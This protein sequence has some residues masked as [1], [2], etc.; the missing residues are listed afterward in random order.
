MKCSHCKIVIDKFI[1]TSKDTKGKPEKQWVNNA[2]KVAIKAKRQAWN[3]L[4]KTNYNDNDLLIKWKQSRNES[5]KITNSA[6]SNYESNIILDSKVNPKSFWSYVKKKT[7]KPGD[8]SS[9]H[10]DNNDIIVKDNEKATLLNNYFLS[11]F[12]TEPDDNFFNVNRVNDVEYTLSS[13]MVEETDISKIIN[14]VGVS[15]SAGPDNIHARLIKE[16]NKIF[17]KIFC[18]IFNKSLGE[19]VLPIQWKQANIK[20]LFKKGKRTSCSN[21]RPVSLTSII[22]KIFES[23]IRDKLLVFLES[24][25]LLSKYQ[26]GF[27]SGHSC[28]TQLLEIMEDFTDFYDQHVS[29][30]CIY[31]D[32]SKAFDR[33]PHERLLT[34]V[35]NMGIRGDLFTWLRGFLSNRIQRVCVN[36][37]FSA[38]G[39]VTSGI[40]QGSVLGPILFSIFINDLPDNIVSNVMIFADDTKIYNSD[41][42]SNILQE[43]L[44]RLFAWSTDW[45][46]PFNIDKC[47]V[48]HYGRNNNGINFTLDGSVVSDDVVIKDLGV[49]FQ[50]NFKFDAHISKITSTANSR[51]GLIRHTFHR[52][53]REGFLVL[54]K[55]LVRPI[56]EYCNQIWSPYL[57]KH[58]LAIEKIQRRATKLLHGMENKSYTERLK[59]LDLPTLFYRRKRSDIIQVFRIITKI[60]C[61]DCD[62][63]FRFTDST[64]RGNH[65]KL[66][67]PRAST[68]IKLRCF[69]HRVVND[70]ND[71]P[72][73]VVMSS[74]INTFKSNLNKFWSNKDYKYD[75]DFCYSH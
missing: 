5:V 21:Y 14:K 25:S 36:G 62:T 44:N 67:K 63:F 47:K 6:R 27:R 45:L 1:P 2:V 3:K 18:L 48:L 51:L 73:Y 55:A 46:L 22:C 53:E 58:H 11:V 65:F 40:P 61:L 32:F 49:Q 41:S 52:I 50:S 71:L 16:C 43:D 23:L 28:L 35:Y 59:S 37:T 42:N 64:T 17:S 10:N 4:R 13:F 15:K 31:L 30:D 54:Y 57:R 33:V 20:A 9:L 34:K 26:H 7:K 66:V 56:L 29:F 24:N 19:G 12:V 75:F 69:S 68:A 72:N 8:V 70:W 39:D 38:W 60:D 74:S